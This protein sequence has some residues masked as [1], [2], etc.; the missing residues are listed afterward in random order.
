MGI[1]PALKSEQV[2]AL[3]IDDAPLVYD[4]FSIETKIL[5]GNYVKGS[6]FLSKEE[7]KKYTMLICVKWTQRLKKLALNT[8]S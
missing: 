4:K 5:V 2:K 7:V 1:D 8:N 6:I 3:V